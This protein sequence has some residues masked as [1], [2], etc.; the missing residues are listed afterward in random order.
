MTWRHTKKPVLLRCVADANLA[1]G[2][3]LLVARVGHGG[4]SAAEGHEGGFAACGEYS[5][6]VSTETEGRGL[7]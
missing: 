5:Q 1:G 4:R 3:V 7:R 2:D 6:K